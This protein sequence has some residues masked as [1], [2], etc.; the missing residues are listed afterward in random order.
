M[1]NPLVLFDNHFIGHR[2]RYSLETQLAIAADLGFD[3]YEEHA[4]EPADEAGWGEARAGADR[5]RFELFGAYL[6]LRGVADE[7]AAAVDGE[8]ERLDGVVEQLARFEPPGY[9]NLAL[10]LPFELSYAYD[11]GGTAEA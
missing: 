11:R 6:T 3:G 2:R 8:L 1:A 10:R 5:H 4:L 9:L 7:E